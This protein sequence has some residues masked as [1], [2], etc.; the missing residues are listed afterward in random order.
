MAIWAEPS[1]GPVSMRRHETQ[2]WSGQARASHGQKQAI[3]TLGGSCGD[4]LRHPDAR[5]KLRT[6]STPAVQNRRHVGPHLG[7]GIVAVP[8][9]HEELVVVRPAVAD[10]S[11]HGQIDRRRLEGLGTGAAPDSAAVLLAGVLGYRD[12]GPLG[13]S[14]IPAA[15]GL[16][17]GPDKGLVSLLPALGL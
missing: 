8:S 5:E 9:G 16:G 15:D 10:G 1:A 14:G 6:S 12:L 3:R 17:E 11:P 2:R 7:T 4:I 13:R